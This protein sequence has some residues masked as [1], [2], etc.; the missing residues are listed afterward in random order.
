V[1]DVRS[2]ERAGFDCSVIID[3]YQPW[4]SDHVDVEQAQLWDLL[5]RRVARG[6]AAADGSL[7]TGRWAVVSTH[8][9]GLSLPVP[10]CLDL[11]RPGCFMHRV[12]MLLAV[13]P[14]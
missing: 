2:A 4:L 12:R 3:H 13:P 10:G 9:R 7:H 11:K 8:R 1:Q 6:G 14:V 5:R